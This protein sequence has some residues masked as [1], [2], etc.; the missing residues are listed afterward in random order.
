MRQRLSPPARDTGTT[1]E[2]VALRAVSKTYRSRGG[3]VAALR[4]VT[5]SFTPGSFT[6]VM[7][8]SGSGKS[9]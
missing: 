1:E 9:T 8:P 4:E 2:A 5:L 6:A 3:P 7:G